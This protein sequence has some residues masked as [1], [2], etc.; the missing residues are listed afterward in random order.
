MAAQARAAAGPHRLI[1]VAVICV[2]LLTPPVEARP[3]LAAAG[4]ESSRAPTMTQVELAAFGS[5]SARRR[6]LVPAREVRLVHSNAGVS[7]GPAIPGAVGTSAPRPTP[8]GTSSTSAIVAW[9]GPIRPVPGT[10]GPD[11]GEASTYGPGYAGLIAVPRRGRWLVRIIWH[12]RSVVRSTN[13]YGPDQRLFPDRVI[14]LDVATFE[15]LSGEDWTRGILA[16]VTV[17][18]LRYLGSDHAPQGAACA[19]WL[20]R[21]A[22]LRQRAVVS[23][24]AASATRAARRVRRGGPLGAPRVGSGSRSR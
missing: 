21:Q 2:S 16:P 23:A 17:Q 1:A 4:H 24:T 13:D 9:S 10:P 7:F 6:G 18:Y 5:R 8:V 20:A 12:G 22:S 15:A 14:D 11:V 19:G 3:A